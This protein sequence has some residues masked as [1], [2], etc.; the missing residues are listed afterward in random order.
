MGLVPDSQS[1]AYLLGRLLAVLQK[2][3]T[4]LNPNLKKNIT[5]RFFTSLST[6]PASVF[7]SLMSLARIHTSGLK[8]KVFMP[9][10]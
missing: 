5:D 7:P 8:E 6:R 4:R 2:Q 1:N 10:A 3:Q 9:P